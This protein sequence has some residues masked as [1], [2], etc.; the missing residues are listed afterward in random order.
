MAIRPF[1]YSCFR[2]GRSISPWSG[3]WGQPVFHLA[4]ALWRLTVS[5]FNLYLRSLTLPL[6][7][8][9]RTTKTGNVPSLSKFS[10]EVVTGSTPFKLRSR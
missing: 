5:R 4:Q 2:G 10:W 8:F 3:G 9:T 6:S 7:S 1:T